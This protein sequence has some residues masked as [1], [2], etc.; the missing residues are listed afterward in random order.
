MAY[1]M[2]PRARQR[3]EAEGGFIIIEVLVSALILAIVAGAV[4]TLITATTRSAASERNHSTA[5]GLAQED[6]ARM[7]TMRVSSLNHLNQTREEKIG[8]TTFKVESKGLFVNN[9]SG[10]SSCSEANDSADYVEITSTVSGSGLVQPVSLQSVV[11]PTSQSLDPS[12]GTLAVQVNNAAGEPVSGVSINGTGTS[13]FNGSSEENGC[14]NFA[15]IPAGNYRVTTSANG[16]IT[17]EGA[18]STTKEIGV[19]ATATQQVV[20][21]FDKPG[22]IEPEFL[23][24]DPTTG[25]LKPAPVDSMELYNAETGVTAATWGTPGGSRAAI[26]KDPSI[27]PF[28]TRYAVY[29]GSCEANNPNPAETKPGNAAGV[30]FVEV[31][32]GGAFAPKIQVPALNLTV[33]YNGGL[34][35]G[36]RVIVTDTK[37]QTTVKRTFTTNSEG[38]LAS[39]TAGVAEAGLPFDIYNV[40]VSAFVNNRYRLIESKNVK[41]ESVTAPTSLALD[42]SSS[43]ASSSTSSN[44]QCS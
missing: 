27:Y 14:A 21:H 32:P 16:L 4:L 5:Y 25:L 30:A 11:S 13:T 9:K 24:V 38:H 29:A 7:R 10:T 34:V 28:K 33:T 6:Q 3:S 26:L 23:Y 43:S 1:G 19:P 35:A 15:D 37:C 36:A 40:C 18:T 2:I 31:K 17:P 12:H 42:L 41:L 39:S 20:V 44:N 22:V 8:G